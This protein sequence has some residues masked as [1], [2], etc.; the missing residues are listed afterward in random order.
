MTKIAQRV[1]AN[2]KQQDLRRQLRYSERLWDSETLL[3]GHLHSSGWGLG[4]GAESPERRAGTKDRWFQR[5]KGG[6][7]IGFWS[8]LKYVYM[9]EGTLRNYI[10]VS[11]KVSL[12]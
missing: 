10:G 12:L 1:H 11:I 4:F 7:R 9:L 6:G 8:I 5:N 3:S 2:T